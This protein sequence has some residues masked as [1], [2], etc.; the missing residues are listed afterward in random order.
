MCDR[1]NSET[2]NR[3]EN[4]AMKM[5]S[6]LLAIL[7]VLALL[8]S[9]AACEGAPSKSEQREKRALHNDAGT[10]EG[11]DATETTEATEDP[12]EATE[13]LKVPKEIVGAWKYTADMA[14]WMEAILNADILP[15]DEGYKALI[16]LLQKIF[17]GFSVPVI[18]ELREDSTYA[19]TFDEAS[20]KNELEAFKERVPELVPEF[21]AWLVETEGMTMEEFEAQLQNMNGMTLDEAYKELEDEILNE[22]DVEGLINGLTMRMQ[23]DKGSFTYSEGILI[24]DNGRASTTYYIELSGDELK[25]IDIEENSDGIFDSLLPMVFTR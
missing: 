2:E 10:S 23:G 8:F 15:E 24:F 1:K 17:D 9:F 12:T 21:V 4:D 6:K 25:I 14:L 5:I 3:K 22:F 18:M 20:L 11:S 19:I 13:E 7:L 16:G